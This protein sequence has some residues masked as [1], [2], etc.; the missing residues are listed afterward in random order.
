MARKKRTQRSH[1]GERISEAAEK[2][3][4]FALNLE[5][6]DNEKLFFVHVTEELF[7]ASDVVISME[8]KFKNNTANVEVEDLVV[9]MSKWLEKLSG[10]LEAHEKEKNNSRKQDVLNLSLIHIS[11]P[12]RPY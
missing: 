12:T 9:K 3:R 11:E 4:A 7:K 6:G 1:I 8:S 5:L 10:R 2:L